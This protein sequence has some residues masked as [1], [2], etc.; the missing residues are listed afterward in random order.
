MKIGAKPDLVF[1][2]CGMLRLQIAEKIGVHLFKMELNF[3]QSAS[4]YILFCRVD[5]ISCS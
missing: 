5:S 2:E 4:R 3:A 1:G